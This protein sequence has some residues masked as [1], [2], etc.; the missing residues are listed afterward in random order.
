MPWRISKTLY[1]HG[2]TATAGNMKPLGGQLAGI[3]RSCSHP[4]WRVRS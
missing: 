3:V 1:C 4:S 2:L